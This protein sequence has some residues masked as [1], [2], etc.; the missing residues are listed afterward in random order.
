MT[1]TTT[2]PSNTIA[3]AAVAEAMRE[4]GEAVALIDVR[5]SGRISPGACD[6]AQNLPLDQ[7]DTFH[8]RTGIGDAARP[9]RS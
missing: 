4:Q 6:A 9:R 3:A 1:T 2:I 7:L 8:G 5:N